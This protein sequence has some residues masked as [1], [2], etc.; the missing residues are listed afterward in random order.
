MRQGWTLIQVLAMLGIIAIVVGISLTTTKCI[1][2]T[3]RAREPAR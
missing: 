3:S 2:R 1:R